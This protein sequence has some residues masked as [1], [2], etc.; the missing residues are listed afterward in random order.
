[1]QIIDLLLNKAP[2]NANLVW[3]WLGLAGSGS[4][5]YTEG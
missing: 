1:M 2:Y 3:G 5:M 4:L